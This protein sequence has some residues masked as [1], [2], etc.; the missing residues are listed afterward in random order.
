MLDIYVFD[1]SFFIL[2]YFIGIKLGID[3]NWKIQTISNSTF[4]LVF[5]RKI[6]WD[7]ND[8]DEH[9]FRWPNLDC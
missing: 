3:Q 5:Q 7:R 2:D 4:V 1:L 8:P 9:F 6:G